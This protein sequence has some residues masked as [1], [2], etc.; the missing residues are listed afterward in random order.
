VLELRNSYGLPAYILR[1]RDFPMRSNI[2]NV[3]PTA[4]RQEQKPYLTEP[5]KTRTY[6]EAMV[7]VGDEKTLHGSEVLLHKVKK[8]KPKCMNGMPSIFKWRE[9]LSTAMRTT[10]PF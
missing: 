9:G 6:D 5:E 4:L 1:T 3:P 10:N 2:R 8:I 7:L